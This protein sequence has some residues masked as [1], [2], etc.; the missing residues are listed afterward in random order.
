MMVNPFAYVESGVFDP[1]LSL[2]CIL[3]SK[4]KGGDD[5]GANHYVSFELKDLARYF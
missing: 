4:F 3:R 5:G 2:Y 1:Y